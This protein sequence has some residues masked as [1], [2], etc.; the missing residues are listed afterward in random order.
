MFSDLTSIEISAIYYHFVD[1][2]ESLE[3]KLNSKMKPLEIDIDLSEDVSIKPIMIIPISDEEVAK[4]KASS[5]YLTAKAIVEKLHPI[6][7]MINEAEP[8]IKKMLNEK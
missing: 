6:V 1:H 4:I 2:V 7:E 5:S 3:I 8:H